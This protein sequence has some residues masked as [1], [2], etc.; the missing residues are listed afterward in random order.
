MIINVSDWDTKYEWKA[1]ALLSLGFGLLGLD[2]WIIGPLFPFI[3]KDL[4]LNYGQIGA[5]AGVLAVTWGISSILMGNVSDRIGRRR[6]LIPAVLLFSLLAG[7]SGIAA[8]FTMLMLLRAVMG[9]TEGA[10]APVS[11]ACTMEASRPTRRGLNLGFQ[12]S[13]F[14]L[15]G[16]GFGPIIA[17]Q[18]L[19]IAPS[20]RWVFLIVALPG[21]VLALLMYRVIREPATPAVPDTAPTEHRWADVLASRN[22]KLAIP[23]T[24]CTMCCIFVISAMMPNY[25]LDYL[26]FTP[27]QM[28]FVMSG[29]GFGGFLGEFVLPGLSDLLGRKLIAAAGFAVTAVLVWFLRGTGAEP[30]AIFMLLFAIGFTGMGLL[31]LFTGPV[32]SEA[33]KPALI[34]SAIGL[35]AGG[36]EIF[37]GGIAPAAGGW[38]AQTWGIQHILDLA[39]VALMVGF[40]ISFF[41]EESAPRLVERRKAKGVNPMLKGSPH[42]L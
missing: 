31:A 28:G 18:L 37:G 33:V 21:V 38:I 14:A 11:A 22:V 1:I 23:A 40:V 2:R 30:T 7:L 20:W 34:G 6:V 4:G 10:Y 27:S 39:L 13:L 42:K 5:L 3:A 36:A 9:V 25:L 32:A 8:S 17:T 26:K 24:F 15:F 41:L 12:Y 29:I 35:V 19:Q 16:F